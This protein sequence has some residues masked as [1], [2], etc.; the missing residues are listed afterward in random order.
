MAQ[1]IKKIHID[2]RYHPNVIAIYLPN[3]KIY[4]CRKII[5]KGESA[6]VTD[7]AGKHAWIEVQDDVE[8]ETT[9]AS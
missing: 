9:S 5:I 8:L 6:I 4:H 7:E 1:E 2:F 3:G